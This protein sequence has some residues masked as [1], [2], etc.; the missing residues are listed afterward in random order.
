M[1]GQKTTMRSRR[2]DGTS[3]RAHVPA[4]KSTEPD[5]PTEAVLAGLDQ[6]RDWQEDLL[7]DLHENPKNV[8]QEHR[9]AGLVADRLRNAGYESCRGGE[10]WRGRY[11]A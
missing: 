11:L 9:T 4:S 1:P 5:S 7:R 10:D 2:S 3:K 6:A 8:L